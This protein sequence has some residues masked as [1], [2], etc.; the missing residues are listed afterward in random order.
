MQ[1]YRREGGKCAQKPHIFTLYE[2]Y[3]PKSF[4][5]QANLSI[6]TI[7]VNCADFYVNIVM[8][9]G[10]TNALPVFIIFNYFPIC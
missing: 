9:T 1:S 2:Y 8:L 5:K 7:F 3:T 4:K 6:S 10:A